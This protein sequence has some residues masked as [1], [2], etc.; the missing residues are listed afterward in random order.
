MRFAQWNPSAARANWAAAE[1]KK[2]LLHLFFAKT[3]EIKRDPVRPI[4]LVVKD[5]D[6]SVD[7][8][9]KILE[10]K[11]SAAKGKRF[12]V[13]HQKGLN[14]GLLNGLYD[15]QHP[16]QKKKTQREIGS[17]M[18]AIRYLNVFSPYWYFKLKDQ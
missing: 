16:G 12:A 14:R 5:F 6:R 13:F 1:N 18:T 10:M 15:E 8:Y 9:E 3:E 4:L 7:F 11:I 17:G 2:T